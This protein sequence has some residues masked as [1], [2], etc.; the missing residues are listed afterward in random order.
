ML[1]TAPIFYSVKISGGVGEISI[2]IVEALQA[3]PNNRNTFDGHPL[4]GCCS[5]ERG[6]LI[7]KEKKV[8]G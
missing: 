8:H 2:P 4:C 3:R 1:K 6:G 7:N 5:A